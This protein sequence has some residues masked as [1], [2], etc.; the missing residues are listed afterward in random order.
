M[1]FALRINVLAK[2]YRLVKL[3]LCSCLAENGGGG[4]QKRGPSP[5][6]VW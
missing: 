3:V 2:G 1:L 4:N 5:S 6:V